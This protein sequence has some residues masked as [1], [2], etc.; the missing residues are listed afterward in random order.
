MKVCFEVK[1]KTE[2]LGV[3]K[4]ESCIWSKKKKNGVGESWESSLC[5]LGVAE[6]VCDIL[7][8][9]GKAETVGLVVR[10]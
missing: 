5:V 1:K 7:E 10:I 4:N 6:S 8:S 3:G 9:N 2:S